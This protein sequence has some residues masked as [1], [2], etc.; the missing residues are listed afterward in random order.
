MAKAHCRGKSIESG[1]AGK[2][3]G[4]Y[5]AHDQDA[6]NPDQVVDEEGD[7]TAADTGDGH[8]DGDELGCFNA[9]L[10]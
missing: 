7:E 2:E 8:L 4:E 1:Q 9:K 5:L 10:I 3:D 6:W